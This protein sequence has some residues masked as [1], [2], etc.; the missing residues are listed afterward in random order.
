MVLPKVTSPLP[1][2]HQYQNA[3]GKG[4]WNLDLTSKAP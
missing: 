3:A 4:T 1:S 2:P